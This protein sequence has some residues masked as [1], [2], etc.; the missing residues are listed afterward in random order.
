MALDDGEYMDAVD[1][2]EDQAGRMAAG[3][4]MTRGA[5]KKGE[6]PRPPMTR[7]QAHM[8]VCSQ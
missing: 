6:R 3:N 1:L 7:L 4:P 8:E 5:G 2:E